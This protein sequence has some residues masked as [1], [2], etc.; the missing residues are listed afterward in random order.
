LSII[1]G[2]LARGAFVLAESVVDVVALRTG[3]KV[4]LLKNTAAGEWICTPKGII[5]AARKIVESGTV[6]GFGFKNERGFTYENFIVFFLIAKAV[7]NKGGD[8]DAGFVLS[9]R[10]GDLIEWNIINYES[11]SNADEAQMADALNRPNRF[12]LEEMKTDFSLTTCVELRM[13][14]LS[15]VFSQNF[16]NSRNLGMSGQMEIRVTEHRG[17]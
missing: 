9:K 14:F 1:L 11:K 12:K 6:D 17:Y 10:I 2:E 5:L 3:H 7:F 13:L 8:E 15:M 4:P 16:S